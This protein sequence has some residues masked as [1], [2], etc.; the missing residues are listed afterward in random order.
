MQIEF[1]ERKNLINLRKH[2]I[3]LSAGLGAINDPDGIVMFDENNSVD[4]DRYVA[5]GRSGSQIL[6]VS[7]TMRDSAE[8]IISVREATKSE[9]AEYWL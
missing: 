8:R 9:K 2:N 5:I 4:E 1:D 6:F 7:F 3:P